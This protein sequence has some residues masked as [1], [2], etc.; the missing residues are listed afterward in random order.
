MTNEFIPDPTA[1]LFVDPTLEVSIE[2]SIKSP[3]SYFDL[4][5]AMKPTVARILA[6]NFRDAYVTEQDFNEYMYHQPKNI[7]CLGYLSE[8]RRVLTVKIDDAKIHITPRELAF[9]AFFDPRTGRLDRVKCYH[10][11]NYD[12]FNYHFVFEQAVDSAHDPT[13]P[14]PRVESINT[15]RGGVARFVVN[16]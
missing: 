7:D 4:P 15:G 3:V 8:Q 6:N 9:D 11:T 10:I 2:S 16:M 13:P 14:P 12:E 1:D 5:S